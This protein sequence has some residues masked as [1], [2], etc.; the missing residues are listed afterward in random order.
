MV[1]RKKR[2][3]DEIAEPRKK[4]REVGFRYEIVVTIIFFMWNK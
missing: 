3:K 1:G 2:D 4:R